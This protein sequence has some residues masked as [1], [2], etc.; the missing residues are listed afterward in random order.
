MELG[1]NGILS[2]AGAGITSKSNPE[3]EWNET[4]E[5]LKTLHRVILE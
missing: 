2:Y 4:E 3:D 5:K 1:N